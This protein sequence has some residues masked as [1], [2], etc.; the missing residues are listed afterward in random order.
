MSELHVHVD[1][2]DTRTF[3]PEQR[4]Q[5]NGGSPIRQRGREKL[6]DALVAREWDIPLMRYNYSY[7]YILY[8][9][10]CGPRLF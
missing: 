4:K 9:S 10:I 8:G 7:F 5:V 1:V 6:G 2:P 3:R